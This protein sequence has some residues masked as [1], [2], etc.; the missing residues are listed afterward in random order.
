MLFTEG[1][2]F[3]LFAA[4]FGLYWSLQSNRLR[5][6]WLLLCS[7]VFYGAWDWRFLGLMFV[8]IT[9]DYGIGRG[10]EAVKTD[11]GRRTWLTISVVANLGILGFFK[12][13]GFFVDSAVALLQ[14][15]G[16][17]VGARTLN[18][19]LPVGISFYTFQSMS[20]T[21]DVYRR[22]M[23]AVRSYTDFAL[24]VAFFPQLVAGPIVR[25]VDFL[26]QLDR[27]RT[28]RDD[29]QVRAA[30][31]LFLM[32]FVKK[33]CVADGIAAAI[34]PVYVAP[35]AWDAASHWLALALYTI[36]VYC[37]FSG[38]SD[39]AIATA[40][41]LGYQLTKNFDW[42]LLATDITDWWRRWHIS[43]STWFR[44]YLYYPLGGNRLGT[45][46]TYVNLWIVFFLCGL[47]HG[48]Q[49]KYVIWG[50][51]CG[52]YLITHRL[53]SQSELGSRPSGR[54]R[55]LIG[56]VLT[57]FGVMMWWPVFRG[58]DFT[59]SGQQIEIL[60]GWSPGGQRNLGAWWY[61]GLAAMLLVHMGTRARLGGA[62]LARLPDWAWALGYGVC[63]ALA[64]AFTAS[65]YQPF[66]YF[67][68]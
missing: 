48:A 56:W 16:L 37:D 39:M 4:A 24:F 51:M 9:L 10:L 29:V 42:P 58:L 13:F 5:K 8:S 14:S 15:I 66:V 22:H 41:L 36:Q 2:F 46:R 34:D 49:W 60:F 47:W 43:L 21:I 61:A 26:P 57:T 44:D 28:W 64:A 6:L 62:G 33:A 3:L 30:L 67:Q 68:F 50:V 32:G 20:Y 55:A 38:Y 53:W 27:V 52:T 63:A 17:D 1:R 31:G 54:A 7:C 40:G 45:V 19:V 65:G 59:R 11:R 35:L 18:V 25:A 23:R 12:Y